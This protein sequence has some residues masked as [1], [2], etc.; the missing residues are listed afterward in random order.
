[1]LTN[2]VIQRVKSGDPNT[3]RDLYLS[4]RNPFLQWLK[5]NYTCSEEDAKDIF[6]LS[7]VIFYDNAMQGKLDKMEVAIK[8]YLIGI[9]KNKMRELQREKNK[10]LDLKNALKQ[11]VIGEVETDQEAY[12]QEVE[13]VRQALTDMGNPCK[14]LLEHYYYFQFSMQEIAQKLGYKSANTVKNSKYQCMLRLQR[15]VTAFINERS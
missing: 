9:G 1:M 15:L 13:I 5:N 7:M 10:T 6:Q 8:T 12:E 2:T 11:L 4:L 3:I 14:S